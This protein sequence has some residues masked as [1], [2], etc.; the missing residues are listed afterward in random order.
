MSRL[1]QCH[2][3]L[4]MTDTDSIF[5]SYQ[6]RRTELE[7]L[8][9]QSLLQSGISI[10]FHHSLTGAT[11]ASDFVRV[12]G[13]LLDWSSID[14]EESYVWKYL[15]TEEPSLASQ[16][17]YLSLRTKNQPYKLKEESGCQFLH[18][19]LASSAK[20]YRIVSYPT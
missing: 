15:I 18:S 9:A 6:R 4:A 16:I 19:I 8:E 1:A 12:L 17:E 13:R 14:N 3:R 7:T 20:V 11:L 2:T 5:L 10:D